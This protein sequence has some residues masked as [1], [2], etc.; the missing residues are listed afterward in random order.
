MYPDSGSFFE[1]I[2]DNPYFV[3][4]HYFQY[5][6]GPIAGRAYDGENYNA[7][8]VNITDV[9]YKPMVKAVKEVNSNLYQRR[10][11]YLKKDK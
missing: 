9:P 7:G 1:S 5:M 10:Y 11:G 2:I 6:D 3:G 8:M 4:A